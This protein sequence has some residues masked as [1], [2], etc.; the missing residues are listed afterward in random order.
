MDLLFPICLC[1]FLRRDS[2]SDPSTLNSS[3]KPKNGDI[4]IPIPRKYF[5][6]PAGGV[7]WS[8]SP[9]NPPPKASNDTDKIAECDVN[10][11]SDLSPLLKSEGKPHIEDVDRSE[12]I[13]LIILPIPAME[14]LHAAGSIDQLLLSRKKG[15]A[16]RAYFQVDIT[17]GGSSL[18]SFSTGTG[19][20][21]F[22][23]FRVDVRT[24]VLPLTSNL[25]SP[26]KREV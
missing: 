17:L 12:A 23:V 1:I 14:S 24:H 4:H 20:N 2:A 8:H 13:P 18:K 26:A 16:F 21:G 22:N 3:R 25:N 5:R 11:Q 10:S 6:Q 9:L 19:N 15:M 7:F